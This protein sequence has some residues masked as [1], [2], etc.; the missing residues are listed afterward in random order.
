VNICKKEAKF[1]KETKE[2]FLSLLLEVLLCIQKGSS[3]EQTRVIVSNF[4]PGVLSCVSGILVSDSKL[5]SNL[6]VSSIKIFELCITSTLSNALPIPAETQVASNAKSLGTQ[7]D[8][9]WYQQTFQ[10]VCAF[11]VQIFSLNRSSSS[12]LAG[13]ARMLRLEHDLLNWR[14]RAEKARAAGS[15]LHRCSTALKP[16]LKTLCDSLMFYAFRED[17]VKDLSSVALG[18]LDSVVLVHRDK[19]F[20]W[21]LQGIENLPHCL[22]SEHEDDSFACIIAVL[23]YTTYLNNDVSVMLGFC[24]PSSTEFSSLLNCLEVDYQDSMA[25]ERETGYYEIRFRLL[26]SRKSRKAMVKLLQTFGSMNGARDLIRHCLFS[27]ESMEQFQSE[28][29]C[30]LAFL[31]KGYL[32]NSEARVDGNIQLFEHIIEELICR[33]NLFIPQ[34]DKQE[35][36]EPKTE[37]PKGIE[38]VALSGLSPILM[39]RKQAFLVSISLQILGL[40]S[41]SNSDV[42]LKYASDLVLP[43]FKLMNYNDFC[44]STASFQTLKRMAR[45]LSVGQFLLSNADY[46]VDSFCYALH[47][48]PRKLETVAMLEYFLDQCSEQS[49]EFL[50]LSIE[51]LFPLISDISRDLLLALDVSIADQVHVLAYLKSLR[52]IIK[53][54]QTLTVSDSTD[55]SSKTELRP[56]YSSQLAIEILKQRLLKRKSQLFY[57]TSNSDSEDTTD[58]DEESTSG[59]ERENR[60]ESGVRDL[61]VVILNKC[62]HFVSHRIDKIRFLALDI[63]VSGLH[64]LQSDENKLL[65]V[66]ATLWTPLQFHFDDLSNRGLFFKTLDVLESMG[67][68]ASQFLSRRIGQE[69]WPC[70]KKLLSELQREQKKVHLDLNQ[71]YHFSS[72]FHYQKRIFDFLAFW[73]Q[74]PQSTKSALLILEEIVECCCSVLLSTRDPT[75]IESVQQVIQAMISV[76]KD[77]CWSIVS[78]HLS[79]NPKSVCLAKMKKAVEQ[80]PEAVYDWYGEF[81]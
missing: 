75:L 19:F 67:H 53:A 72:H 7:C 60:D 31:L 41:E 45:P 77:C 38:E 57:E 9:K 21:M 10:K 34:E 42:L 29:L 61:A 65:P 33:R 25:I 20:E 71:T 81:V 35:S 74:Q 40:V 66:I 68:I 24:R 2:G 47:Y 13:G 51:D 18:E 50:D 54:I 80:D 55:E 17:D 52:A 39:K 56:E 3:P 32:L 78:Y 22:R 58:E 27:L 63:V 37:S 16:V 1:K 12:L 69:L 26:P 8:F 76:D 48:E 79:M 44:I 49:E 30:L 15:L 5:G 23:G 59:L 73:L 36:S 4:L 62:Q 64:I 6:F 70:M 46:L 28:L 11:V 43:L 14:F